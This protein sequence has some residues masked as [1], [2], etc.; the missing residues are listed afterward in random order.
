M[1]LRDNFLYANPE[2][3]KMLQNDYRLKDICTSV[4]LSRQSIMSEPFPI[5][6][7]KEET[8]FDYNDFSILNYVKYLLCMILNRELNSKLVYKHCNCS[9]SD[10]KNL[11]SIIQ[12]SF[13]IAHAKYIEYFS[14]IGSIEVQMNSMQRGNKIVE[15]ELNITLNEVYK[16]ALLDTFLFLNGC[17]MVKKSIIEQKIVNR[18][19]SEYEL[20]KVLYNWVV[21]HTRYDSSF[22]NYSFSGYSALFFGYAVCQGYTALYNALC[23]LFGLNIVGMSGE[24]YNRDMGRTEK[25][26]WSF[27]LLDNKNVYIDVTWGHPNFKNEDDLKRYG[28]DTNLLCDFSFFD[29]PYNILQKDHKWDKSLYG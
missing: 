4:F 21:L 16:G 7:R 17:V 11:M 29:I 3:H 23:K 9:V 28:I 27:A 10:A 19:M 20:A 2:I 14:G 25:H 12:K 15:I 6:F 24:G 22:N 5:L 18:N 1:S 13:E 26:I 8:N